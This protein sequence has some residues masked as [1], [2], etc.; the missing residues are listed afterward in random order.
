MLRPSELV[1]CMLNTRKA[2]QQKL[3]CHRFASSKIWT[4]EL[5]ASM[6]QVPRS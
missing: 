4:A 5:K 1:S 2:N 6:Y 3:L